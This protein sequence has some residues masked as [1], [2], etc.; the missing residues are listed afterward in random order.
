[1]APTRELANQISVVAKMFGS[2]SIIRSTCVYGGA[3][4]IPQIQSLRSG[5]EVRDVILIKKTAI[6]CDKSN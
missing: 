4:R 2:S 6:I 5:V 1:M 3:S